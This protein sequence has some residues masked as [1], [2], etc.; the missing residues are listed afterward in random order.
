[1]P[2]DRPDDTQHLLIDGRRVPSA[3]GRTFATIDPAT[4]QPIAL[5]A[6]ADACD[7]DA[8]VRAARAAFEGEWGQ[9]RAAERGHVLMRL[10]ALIRDNLDALVT[11][12]SL[13]SGKPVAAIRRQ[14]LPAVLDTLTYYAGWADKINGQV[15]PARPD[16]LT[17]TV[18]EPLGV[19]G[20]IVPWNFPLM[21]GMWK[22]APALACGCTIVLKPAELTPLTA[23]RIG[24][25]ALE[26][27]LPPGVLNVVPGAGKVAGAAL[28]DH[29]DVD[30]VTFTGSPSVGREIL[31]GAAGNL[32]RVTLELGGKSAN[33]IFPD[34]DLGA[35]V[36]AAAAGIFF[37]S[38]QVCSAGSR[39]LVHEA[40]YDEVVERLVE[41]AHAV[42]VGD[43]RDP[44]VTMGPLVSAGQMARVLDYIAIGRD[45]GA[46]L[47]TGGTRHGGRGYFVAPTVFA[48]VA[49]DMR[50]AQ[51]EI[52]GPVAA[53]IP[54]RDDEEAIRLANGTRYGLAAGVW[55]A[56]ITRV[57]RFARRLK[58]GTVWVNTYG[59][60]DVRLPWGGARDSGFGR[61]HGDAAI[62]NFTEPKVVWI[63]TGG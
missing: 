5:V 38:G 26:A 51:E 17:Y 57:H 9:G 40:I 56:D 4:E 32:K 47:A 2:Y 37:N 35:A 59:P 13:D 11:L 21:I 62:E 23:L 22:V 50:I 28:V 6:E 39:I 58:A 45:E 61:E 29:P 52:F 19:V 54:F 3:A 63:N 43:P 48:G 8:A 18:R 7:V 36:R 27:G 31:R 60:T 20:A 55:S 16:A 41:R 46:R 34:A 30:K 42:R 33:I 49:H 25:L 15:I 10:A 44:A 14:D 24:E 1:M 12:E 53:V